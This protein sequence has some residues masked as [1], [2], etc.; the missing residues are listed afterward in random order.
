M[1]KIKVLQAICWI[2]VAMVGVMIVAVIIVT[3]RA[4]SGSPAVDA[5]E[6]AA[7]VGAPEGPR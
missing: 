3:A 7:A 5:E 6:R 2:L 4:A 1:G